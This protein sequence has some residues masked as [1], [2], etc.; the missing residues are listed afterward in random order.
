[1]LIGDHDQ[2]NQHG[3]KIDDN[4][5]KKYAEI[6]TL[7]GGGKKDESRKLL[8]KFEVES[9]EGGPFQIAEIYAWYGEKEKAFEWLDLAFKYNDHGLTE[10]KISVFF[11]PYQDDPR[12][13]D[14]LKKL[15][16]PL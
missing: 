16:F 6:I 13:A 7:W 14:A 15:K 5:W 11:K 12:Y 2:A 9:K 1:M 3:Q 4:F 10:I 8:K